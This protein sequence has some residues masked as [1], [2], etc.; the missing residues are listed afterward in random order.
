GK[1]GKN[2]KSAKKG[3]EN[4][5]K[6]RAEPYKII[7]CAEK[8]RFSAAAKEYFRARPFLMYS[9]QGHPAFSFTV[10]FYPNMGMQQLL[11][12]ISDMA[13]FFGSVFPSNCFICILFFFNLLF[14]FLLLSIG[15]LGMPNDVGS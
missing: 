5:P 11:S 12:G 13:G 9:C 1:R 14:L 8:S 4:T 15:N 6:F 7:I 2:K 10:P 3:L